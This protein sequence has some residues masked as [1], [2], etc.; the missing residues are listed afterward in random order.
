[1]KFLQKVIYIIMKKKKI[2]QSFVLAVS[3]LMLTGCPSTLPPNP[4]TDIYAYIYSPVDSVYTRYYSMPD[5]KRQKHEQQLV[6]SSKVHAIEW[7]SG[8]SKIYGEDYTP[9]YNDL[10]V[11]KIGNNGTVYVLRSNSVVVNGEVV[12]WD[13]F[14]S[15]YYNQ[16]ASLS[17]FPYI[18]QVI[19]SLLIYFP[20]T[21]VLI[22]DLQEHSIY[23]DRLSSAP[24]SVSISM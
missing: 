5:G 12:A 2:I 8:H 1:M 4:D 21:I 15:K 22:D 23:N 3:L 7:Y 11:R 17:S 14:P 18:E 24:P 9:E 6:P 13:H 20:E 10:H 19:D 16:D